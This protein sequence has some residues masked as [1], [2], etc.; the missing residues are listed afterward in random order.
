MVTVSNVTNA[1]TTQLTPISF[2]ILLQMRFQKILIHRINNIMHDE[3]NRTVMG[4]YKPHSVSA[5]LL[6]H[7][8]EVPEVI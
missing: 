8:K 5:L 2:K 3:I 4:E 6:L 1:S 7:K